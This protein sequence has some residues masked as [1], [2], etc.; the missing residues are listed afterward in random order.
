MPVHEKSAIRK[1]IEAVG[2]SVVGLGSTVLHTAAGSVEGAVEGLRDNKLENKDKDYRH[3]STG[4]FTFTNMAAL[5]GI[6]AGAA[7]ML[8]AGPVGTAIAA[9]G[10]LLAGAAMRAFEGSDKT[11]K[12]VEKID[13]NVDKAVKDNK[14]DNKSSVTGQNLAEG[15]VVGMKAAAKHSWDI[16]YEGG[17]NAT[18]FGI[19]VGR[20]IVSGFVELGKDAIGL[21]PKEGEVKKSGN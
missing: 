14:G 16:G 6:S 2:G 3:V 11:E 17:K 5:T 10:G 13:L 20:G 7:Y 12:L 19:D 15:A 4:L 8:G 1:G 21:G 9:G 18:G